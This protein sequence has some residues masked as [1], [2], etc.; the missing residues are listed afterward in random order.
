M[1]DTPGG[2]GYTT[3]PRLKISTDLPTTNLEVWDTAS[4]ILWPPMLI[5]YAV[6]VLSTLAVLGVAIMAYVRVRRHMQASETTLRRALE[7]IEREH[8]PQPSRRI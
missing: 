1:T 3:E 7:E 5:L 2:E 6:L 8:E 4:D